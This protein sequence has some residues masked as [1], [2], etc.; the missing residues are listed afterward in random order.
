MNAS[1]AVSPPLA[2]RPSSQAKTTKQATTSASVTTGVRR[3]GL[4]SRSGIT[5]PLRS[6]LLGGLRA[7]LALAAPAGRAGRRPGWPSSSGPATATRI[8]WLTPSWDSQT[9]VAGWPSA[10]GTT[11]IPRRSVQSVGL[12]GQAVLAVVRA[13]RLVQG[14]DPGVRSVEAV[15]VALAPG[16]AGRDERVARGR[17]QDRVL[18][19][20]RRPSP[21]SCR[22]RT[23]SIEPSSAAKM[24]PSMYVEV[25]LATRPAAVASQWVGLAGKPLPSAAGE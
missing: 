16:R 6:G 17:P 15:D 14:D 3:V 9:R 7:G 21:R 12:A 10:P 4:A 20:P 24:S 11:Y 23:A 25:I 2:R 5:G 13:V 8:A 22:R 19:D 1:S 18:R